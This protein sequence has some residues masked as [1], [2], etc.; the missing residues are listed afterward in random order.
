MNA[1]DWEFALLPLAQE[2][3]LCDQLVLPFSNPT[4][5]LLLYLIQVFCGCRLTTALFSSISTFSRAQVICDSGYRHENKVIFPFF[6][7][8]PGR[9][10]LTLCNNVQTRRGVGGKSGKKQGWSCHTDAVIKLKLNPAHAEKM[11]TNNH[12]HR[13]IC[14]FSFLSTNRMPTVPL[15]FIGI[16]KHGILFFV[17]PSFLRVID[18]HYDF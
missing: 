4:L 6:C 13:D 10:M 2:L 15:G 5:L 8:C 12:I 14:L 18:L 16:I 11:G 3:L 9:N 1:S 17:H 7:K